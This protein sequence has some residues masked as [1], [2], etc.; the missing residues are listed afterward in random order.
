M[1]SCWHGISLLGNKFL[2]AGI[3]Q[4]FLDLFLQHSWNLYKRLF[5]IHNLLGLQHCHP[6][7]SSFPKKQSKDKST[8]RRSPTF[9]ERISLNGDHY[10]APSLID[11]MV[12]LV[13]FPL[14]A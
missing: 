2:A 7:F 9:P 3:D 11:L 12:M 14:K 4:D 13:P 8:H 1:L 6:T 10:W 5:A